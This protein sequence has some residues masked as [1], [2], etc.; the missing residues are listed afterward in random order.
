MRKEF[1]TEGL[2]LVCPLCETEYVRAEDRFRTL[3]PC[4]DPERTE[5][6]PVRTGGKR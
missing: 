3:Y 2:Y 6:L 4:R 1:S 5:R